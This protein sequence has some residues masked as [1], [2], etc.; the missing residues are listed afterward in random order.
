MLRDP[1]ANSLAT[2]FFEPWMLR[3]ALDRAQSIDD[4]L[5]RAL[6]T[7]T[8]LFLQNQIQDDHNAIDLWTANYTFINERVARH[9]DSRLGNAVIAPARVPD[10]SSA[11][12]VYAILLR[13]PGMREHVQASLRADGI[14][15]AIYYPRPLHLQPAYRGRLALG[16]SHCRATELAAEQVLSLPIYP[17]LTDAQVAQ[18]CDALRRL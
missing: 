1:K 16:P 4:T 17:E 9:Y 8:R 18:V 10:S 11:W 2:N 6:E 3:G 14:P 5:R 13:D 7:E 15:T 12:A